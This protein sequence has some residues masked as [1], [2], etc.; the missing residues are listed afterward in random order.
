VSV[1]RRAERPP[2]QKKRGPF[3]LECSC[4]VEPSAMANP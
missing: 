2:G 1:K 4:G 3:G